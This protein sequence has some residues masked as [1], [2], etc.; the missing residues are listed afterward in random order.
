MA[1]F[2]P[3]PQFVQNVE[4][5]FGVIYRAM[6]LIMSV[7]ERKKLARGGLNVLHEKMLGD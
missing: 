3:I 6:F 2:N 4:K 1:Q 7:K 5:R